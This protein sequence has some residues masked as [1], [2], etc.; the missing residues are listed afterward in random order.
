ML[1]LEP[2]SWVHAPHDDRL[3][4]EPVLRAVDDAAHPE[5]PVAERV[6]R[7]VEVAD[8]VH[9]ALSVTAR[10]VR[11]AQLPISSQRT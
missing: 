11:H 2:Y 7:A 4:E 3:L 6:Q 1:P 10:S 8:G 5:L 9:Q